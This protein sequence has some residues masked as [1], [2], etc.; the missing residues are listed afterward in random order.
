MEHKCGTVTP[1]PPWSAHSSI[2]RRRFGLQVKVPH[3]C[4]QN[5][6]TTF[7]P[8][9]NS[10]TAQLLKKIQK[11]KGIPIASNR[12]FSNKIHRLKFN[13]LT[14]VSES[15]CCTCFVLLISCSSISISL[16][17]LWWVSL[18]SLLWGLAAG[19]PSSKSRFL[20]NL[21]YVLIGIQ[22]F[23]HLLHMLKWKTF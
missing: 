14:S 3:F 10:K 5:H 18:L 17:P 7:F 6:I 19:D 20:V 16:P 2:W 15:R 11:K 4:I 21:H 1:P 13:V 9:R 8:S 12:Q 23:I 22:I